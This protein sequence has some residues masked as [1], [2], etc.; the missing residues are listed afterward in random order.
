MNSRIAKPY[1]QSFAT[2]KSTFKLK[3]T[4]T[5]GDYISRIKAKTV[6]CK[7]PLTC[8]DTFV[9]N[10]NARYL[11][12]RA[13]LDQSLLDKVSFGA[14]NLN[15]N[16]FT[17]LD[18][19]NVCVVQNNLGVCGPSIDANFDAT[20]KIDP[21]GELF[22]NTICG[23]YNYQQYLALISD[24]ESKYTMLN[25]PIE[26]PIENPNTNLDSKVTELDTKLTDLYNYLFR[27]QTI[28]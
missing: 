27:K 26:N 9:G 8:H 15:L 18:L 28:N 16:L 4:A 24:S 21:E 23:T 14:G 22:G 11:L 17:K 3:D 2:G 10:Y 20:Y 7:Y 19:K 25:N 6:Y 1:A 12:E 5:A 13:K